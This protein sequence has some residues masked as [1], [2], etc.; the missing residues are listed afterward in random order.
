MTEL[1]KNKYRIP[2]ARLTNWDYGSNASYFITICT[3]DSYC[4]FGEIVETRFIASSLGKLAEKH[5]QE[6]PH[7]F[8]YVKLDVFVVMPN[9]IHGILIIDKSQTENEIQNIG[10]IHLSVETQFITS[11]IIAPN[12]IKEPIIEQKPKGGGFAG[13]INPMLNDNISRIIR[14][15][16]GKCTFEMRKIHADFAWQSRFHDHII[17]NDESYKH[18]GQYILDNPARWQDDKFYKD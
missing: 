6:I 14:W 1:F 11:Q 8:P 17:R 7:H 10:E 12:T 5:W 9:H 2:S 18:I 15:Y 16:K 13:N 3:K 4:Y